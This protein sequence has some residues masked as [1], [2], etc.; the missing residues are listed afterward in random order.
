MSARADTPV[1]AAAPVPYGE[2][3]RE[4]MQATILTAVRGLVDERPWGSITMSEVARRAG[5]SRQ[6]LYNEFGNRKELARTYALSVTAGLLDRVEAEAL[7]HAG[8]P[9]A[10]LLGAFSLFL[11]IAADEPIV[12][13]LT[14]P[15]G[16][17]DLAALVGS[18]EGVPILHAA[19]ERI[20]NVMQ[21]VA[22]GAD[23]EDVAALADVVVRLAMSHLSVPAGSVEDA[24]AT[25]ARVVGPA[26]DTLAPPG[27]ARR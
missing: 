22:P 9:R 1:G 12:R 18:P 4:L 10:A 25:L 5:V 7:A 16:A 8:D 3:A 11:T 17:D 2:A 15:S 14:A 21:T 24:T 20:R 19:S 27:S 6:T 23:R 26:L 13:A